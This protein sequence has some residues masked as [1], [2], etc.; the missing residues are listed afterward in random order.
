MS[1]SIVGPWRKECANHGDFHADGDSMSRCFPG[2]SQNLTQNESQHHK[3]EEKRTS[4]K[5]TGTQEHPAHAFSQRI[6]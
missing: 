4:T 5:L 3:L 2:V 6:Q 1:A